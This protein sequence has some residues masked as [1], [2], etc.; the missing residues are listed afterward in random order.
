MFVNIL[1]ARKI[2]K[3][4]KSLEKPGECQIG[5]TKCTNIQDMCISGGHS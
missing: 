1:L 3:I 4:S 2:L 5:Q